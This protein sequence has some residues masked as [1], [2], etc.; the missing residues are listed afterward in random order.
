MLKNPLPAS[1]HLP[2]CMCSI[3]CKE[4]KLIYSSDHRLMKEKQEFDA[5]APDMPFDIVVSRCLAEF[6]CNELDYEFERA[7]IGGGSDEVSHTGAVAYHASFDT[8]D[9]F[10][11]Q[12][13]E[14]YRNAAADAAADYR[15][16]FTGLDYNF[17]IMDFKKPGCSLRVHWHSRIKFIFSF[18]VRFL[19]GERLSRMH[20]Y[21]FAG[22]HAVFADT[23]RYDR[24]MH[25]LRQV[26]QLD[27]DRRFFLS[28]FVGENGCVEKLSLDVE[29][30]N[31]RHYEFAG[32]ATESFRAKLEAKLGKKNSPLPT[33]CAAILA[34][35]GEDE[36]ENIAKSCC[37]SIFSF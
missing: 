17:I 33:L 1:A 13:D 9:S 37:S 6:I 31:D 8:L 35:F 34:D 5:E 11:Y 23:L 15:G 14:H 32:A 24:S 16:W 2:S 26:I 27:A 29:E 4:G 21:L 30:A 19:E 7:L 3:E 25:K 12:V 10:V 22:K 28:T 18:D 36:L 20:D